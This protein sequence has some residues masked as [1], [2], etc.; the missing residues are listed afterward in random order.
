MCLDVEIL[1]DFK[2]LL[3]LLIGK[4]CNKLGFEG[5]RILGVKGI[6]GYQA[7]DC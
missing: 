5:S 4:Y 2:T 6:L 1:Y 3:S 7:E